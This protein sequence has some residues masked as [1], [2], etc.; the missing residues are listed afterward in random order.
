M[1]TVTLRLED[2]IYS[3]FKIAADGEKRTLSN[4]IEFAAHNFL[5]EDSFVSDHEMNE[6]INDKKLILS[7]RKGVKDIIKGRYKI[8]K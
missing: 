1:K 4:Y 7:L 6:I 5:I 2:D 3:M 8:V